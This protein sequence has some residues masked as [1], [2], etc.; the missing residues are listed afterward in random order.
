MGGKGFMVSSRLIRAEMVLRA[1]RLPD[2]LGARGGL[3]R[4]EEGTIHRHG[5]GYGGI[6]TCEVCHET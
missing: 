2:D 3:S 4:W 6:K 1:E 5:A